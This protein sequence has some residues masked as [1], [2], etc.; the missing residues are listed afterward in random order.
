MEADSSSGSFLRH[1]DSCETIGNLDYVICEIC[2]EATTIEADYNFNGGR[3]ICHKSVVLL[4][5]ECCRLVHLHC[6]YNQAELDITSIDFDHLFTC[7][8]CQQNGPEE[9]ANNI[10]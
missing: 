6:F 9:E 3:I 4:V 10:H 1:W 2:K 7:E 5:C 8:D